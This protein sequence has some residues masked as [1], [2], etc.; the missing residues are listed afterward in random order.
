MIDHVSAEK[1]VAAL[2]AELLQLRQAL[3]SRTVIGEAKGILME[4]FAMSEE[5]AFLY[6]RRLS[7]DHEIRVRDIAEDLVRTRV[8]PRKAGHR[9]SLACDA[10]DTE[11]RGVSDAVFRGHLAED[12][13]VVA[14]EPPLVEKAQTHRHRL[15]RG[16]GR[17][18]CLQSGVGTTQPNHAQVRHRRHAHLALE[19][20]LERS[21]AE[22]ELRGQAHGRPRLGWTVL[23]GST[24]V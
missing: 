14:G 9:P 11:A 7:S 21:D 5:E 22:V 17:G 12:G 15:D 2:E 23:D 8:V 19:P 20:G 18:R 4:R 6:L 13:A 10:S 16:L 1:D 3:L 24:R